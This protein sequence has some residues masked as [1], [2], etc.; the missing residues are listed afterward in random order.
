MGYCCWKTRRAGNRNGSAKNEPLVA[1]SPRGSFFPDAHDRIERTEGVG[2]A[3]V[4]NG[5]F[6]SLAID[7]MAIFVLAGRQ[8]QPGAPDALLTAFEG[9]G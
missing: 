6:L 7:D 2:F 1:V 9:A 3:V 5:V 4:A 8:V